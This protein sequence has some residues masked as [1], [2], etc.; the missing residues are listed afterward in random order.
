MQ[1]LEDDAEA[2]LAF[3][4][5]PEQ[6]VELEF[7]IR[8][9]EHGKF[10]TYLQEAEAGHEIM[11]HAASSSFVI[12]KNSLNPRCFI[13]GGTGLAPFLSML[14]RMS[15][16]EEDFPTHLILGVHHESEVFCQQKLKSLQNNLPQLT[17]ETCVWKP[18]NNWQGFIGTPVE[19]LQNYLK[20]HAPLA[21]IYLYGAPA[22]VEAASETAI[23]AGIDKQQ[24][25]QQ[26]S[27]K[28][29]K[30]QIQPLI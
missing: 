25:Y 12:N 6:F 24:I 21:D 2:G 17:I 9:Q 10:S 16:W 30:I 18:Q 20:K 5:E 7:L 19:A 23:S 15:E 28:P 3:E 26:F 4:F 8:I 1:Q 11:V 13:T 27:L 29:Q 22:L 14:T